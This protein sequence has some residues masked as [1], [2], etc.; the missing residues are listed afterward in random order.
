MKII[1]EAPVG[2]PQDQR[3]ERCCGHVD[4]SAVDSQYQSSQLL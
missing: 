1:P 4:K 2:K 3:G